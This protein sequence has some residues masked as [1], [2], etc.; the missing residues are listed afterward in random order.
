MEGIRQL[1]VYSYATNK[2]TKSEARTMVIKALRFPDSVKRLEEEPSDKAMALKESFKPDTNSPS[3]EMQL[4]NNNN[5]LITVTEDLDVNRDTPLKN[6]L[7]IQCKPLKPD[8]T[9]YVDT[10]D[11][12]WGHK[13]SRVKNLPVC[14]AS[15]SSTVQGL[16]PTDILGQYDSIEA[17]EQGKGNIVR[18]SSRTGD[19]NPSSMQQTQREIGLSPHFWNSEY[20]NRSSQPKE[21]TSVRVGVTLDMV[22]PS[23]EAM[24]FSK[25]KIDAFAARQNKKP[26]AYWSQLPDPN[27]QAIDAFHQKWPN[28]GLYLNP[29]W[30]LIPKILRKI[31]EDKLKEAVLITPLWPTHRMDVIF[32]KRMTEGLT[33]EDVDFLAQST[34]TKTHKAYDHGWRVWSNWCNK[35]GIDSRA[36]DP[37]SVYR[38]LHEHAHLSAPTLNV[39]RSSI[40]S[41]FN[42]IYEDKRYIAEDP[43]IISFFQAKGKSEVK[44]PAIGKQEIWD[45]QQLITYFRGWSPNARLDLARLQKKTIVWIGIVSMMRPRSDLGRLQYRDEAFS[46]LEG[47]QPLGVS[48][49]SKESKESQWKTIKI[50]TAEQAK[51]GD[52]PVRTLA[53]FMDCTS[54]LRH[55]LPDDH[56]LF[57]AGIEKG[58]Q[59]HSIKPAA[60]A[61]W[62]QQTMQEAGIDTKV[63]KAHS[64]RAAAS[65]WAV[66]HGHKIEQVKKHANWSSNSDAFEKYYCKLFNKFQE[67]QATSDT[68]F[69]TTDN[70]TTSSEPGTEATIIGISMTSNQAVAEVEREDEAAICPSTFNWLSSL[71]F[72]SQDK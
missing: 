16:D 17:C 27:A 62:I 1:A 59:V 56:T 29:P 7:P 11:S 52:C 13:C 30:R 68:F 40:A 34:R 72:P 66:M 22:Q 46:W 20:N 9:I 50:G 24:R 39:Y 54:S 67:S 4:D 42:I 69:S 18:D 41:V 5:H 65:T 58:E 12:G 6:S 37:K 38:F 48:L 36:Y 32:Q 33:I 19:S 60:T 57:L 28:K 43:L 63:Y 70:A 21:G 51:E 15:S 45:I 64:L 44:I 53:E 8:L 61:S 2:T 71:L 23:K 35:H 3:L 26:P 47:G 10:P 14:A 55:G 25:F 31:K 49:T